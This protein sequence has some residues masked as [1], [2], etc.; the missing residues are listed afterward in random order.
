MRNKVNGLQLGR[1]QTR[2]THQAHAKSICNRTVPYRE[3]QIYRVKK[4]KV[5]RRPESFGRRDLY[6]G[7]EIRENK[8]AK[9]NGQKK[10]PQREERKDESLSGRRTRV[11]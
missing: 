3:M 5:C 2:G 8:F 1:A 4:K 6:A 11:K 10:A 7:C 9:V